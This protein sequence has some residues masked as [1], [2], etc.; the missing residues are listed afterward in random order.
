MVAL[1]LLHVHTWYMHLQLSSLLVELCTWLLDSGLL[2]LTL[3]PTFSDMNIANLAHYYFYLCV[4]S[5]NLMGI[6]VKLTQ[7]SLENCRNHLVCYTF[8]VWLDIFCQGAF[9][10]MSVR[11]QWTSCTLMFTSFNGLGIIRYYITERISKFYYLFNTR[12]V[13]NLETHVTFFQRSCCLF[14]YTI[15]SFIFPFLFITSFFLSIGNIAKDLYSSY[16]ILLLLHVMLWDFQLYFLLIYRVLH[17][18]ASVCS[19]SC[20]LSLLNFLLISCTVFII[21]SNCLC[22]LLYL[23]PL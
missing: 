21:S 22:I 20:S 1:T 14:S 13:N 4:I 6:F 17:S 10:I 3:K 7:L 12:N 2:L 8:G 11:G 5:V 9:L 15:S 16:N 23:T 18:S 19:L